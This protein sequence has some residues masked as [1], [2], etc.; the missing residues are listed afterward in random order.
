MHL[1]DLACS[2]YKLLAG[3]LWGLPTARK[4]KQ[5]TGRSFHGFP[6]DRKLPNDR[7]IPAINSPWRGKFLTYI[8][9]L[10]GGYR[11]Q[12]RRQWH[13]ESELINY[14]TTK[15]SHPREILKQPPAFVIV[16]THSLQLWRI[17][18]RKWSHQG[19]ASTT[20]PKCSNNSSW[21]EQVPKEV[22]R[23]EPH[24][25]RHGLVPGHKSH[26]RDKH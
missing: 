5:T 13:H 26:E 14:A 1:P 15:S 12:P 4:Y 16:C 7:R 18:T 9:D 22:I 8:L 20:H 17:S 3:V 21:R 19:R 6:P 2:K 10:R 23:E 24:Y 25:Y 11:G